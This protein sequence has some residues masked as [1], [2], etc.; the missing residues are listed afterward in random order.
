LRSL[1]EN[2]RNIVN[3]ISW[4]M[5]LCLKML[6]KVIIVV[7]AWRERYYERHKRFFR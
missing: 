2:S 4:G 6:A 5:L 7:T 3:T 1:I